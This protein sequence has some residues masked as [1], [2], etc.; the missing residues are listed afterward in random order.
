MRS[1]REFRLSRLAKKLGIV[2][3][4]S[5]TSEYARRRGAIKRQLNHAPTVRPIAIH[6]SMSPEA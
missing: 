5:A 1:C 3:A 2:I 4:L 6:A